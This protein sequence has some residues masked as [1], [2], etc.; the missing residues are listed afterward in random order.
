[1]VTGCRVEPAAHRTVVAQP[2]AEQPTVAT[3][4]VDQDYDD[5]ASD[6]TYDYEEPYAYEAPYTAE[7]ASGVYYDEPPVRQNVVVFRAPPPL[8]HVEPDIYV[9]ENVGAAIYFVGGAYW[10]FRG[11]R[12][13]SASYW[14]APWVHVDFGR[15][16]RVVV[17]RPHNHYVHYR[18]PARAEVWR[19]PRVHSRA[20]DGRRVRA[21]LE[22]VP[23]RTTRAT[24]HRA[25]TRPAPPARITE[26]PRT[27]RPPRTTHPQRVSEPP[28]R[29]VPREA[30]PARRIERPVA[31]TRVERAP[32][33]PQR[34]KVDA[35]RRERAAPP[36]KAE[37]PRK[38]RVIRPV[39]RPNADET[40]R[41][42]GAPPPPNQGAEKER[43][44][45]QEK[46][47]GQERQQQK[48]R[49]KEKDKGKRQR[50]R[51]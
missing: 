24:E 6:D 9:V 36:S 12:W 48:Q 14:N 32:P 49:Q 8:V 50:P 20:D 23:V 29:V 37:Q 47:R 22:R 35:P 44:R 7:P 18:R 21:R 39:T 26:P 25:I 41:S 31:P 43:V 33:P 42:R 4:Q 51:A 45:E 10:Q 16:P 27:T 19:E 30:A 5:T 46:A 40:R 1:M 34:P 17:H 13:Y 2:V 11:G 3:Q 38:P 15:V 28:R